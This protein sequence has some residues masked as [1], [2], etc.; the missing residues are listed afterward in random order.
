MTE[1]PTVGHNSGIAGDRLKT[2]VERIQRLE[3]EKS[4]V[5]EDIKDIFTEVKAAGFD[6]KV[7]RQLLR[8]QKMDAA[9]REEQDALLELYERVFG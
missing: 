9:E 7:V 8:R 5:A 3:T 1:A 4:G 2:Y 6:T